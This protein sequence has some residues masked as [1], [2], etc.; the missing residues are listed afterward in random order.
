MVI[1]IGTHKNGH[2]QRKSMHAYTF[3]HVHIVIDIT[4]PLEQGKTYTAHTVIQA[5]T[6]KSAHPNIYRY[7]YVG[8]HI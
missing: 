8:T 6:H 3:T 4:G 7:T 2:T 5:L 1:K